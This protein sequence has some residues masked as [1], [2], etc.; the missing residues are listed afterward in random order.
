M[1]SDGMDIQTMVRV[2]MW[3]VPGVCVILGIFAIV[4]GDTSGMKLVSGD[5]WT[6]FYIGILAYAAE[7]LLY[8]A[9]KRKQG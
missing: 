1:A 9:T 2:G 3:G 6:F 7:I 4:I 8:Y 5:G